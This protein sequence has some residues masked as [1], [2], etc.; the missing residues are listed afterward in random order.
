MKESWVV[1]DFIVTI[2]FVRSTDSPLLYKS[3]SASFQKILS[4]RYSLRVE[5]S[6]FVKFVK[7]LNK[8]KSHQTQYPETECECGNCDIRR[9]IYLP[10]INIFETSFHNKRTFVFDQNFCDAIIKIHRR[11][12]E[13]LQRSDND[14]NHVLRIRQ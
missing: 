8:I 14:N 5:Y 7:W 3:Y 6:T 2:N 13:V 9:F 10:N 1:S 11:A 12:E 4:N